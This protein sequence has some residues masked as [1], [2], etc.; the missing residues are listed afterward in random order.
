MN[1]NFEFWKNFFLQNVSLMWTIE[2]G[3][4][5]INSI[6]YYY[7]FYFDSRPREMWAENF[8]NPKNMHSKFITL[9]FVLFFCQGYVRAR[10][11][12]KKWTPGSYGSTLAGNLFF[13][14]LNNRFFFLFFFFV[15]VAIF[16]RFLCFREK[17]SF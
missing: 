4:V 8:L 14:S 10:V 3:R 9:P 17:K 2:Q 15:V 7:M 12:S 11:G 6:R 16:E 5:D 1:C 13:P